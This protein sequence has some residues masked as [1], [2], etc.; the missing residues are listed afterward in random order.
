MLIYKIRDIR[1]LAS[2]S[3]RYL[4][5]ISDHSF[6]D[7]DVLKPNSCEQHGADLVHFNAKKGIKRSFFWGEMDHAEQEHRSLASH[8]TLL[9]PARVYMRP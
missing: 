6:T 2:I 5:Q 1:V 8:L 4:V 3:V 7:R 9:I